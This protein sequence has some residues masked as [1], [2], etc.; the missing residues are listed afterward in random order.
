M[1][2]RVKD[3]GVDD[4]A[5]VPVETVA[6]DDALYNDGTG[7]TR[8]ADEGLMRPA[9]MS[10]VQLYIPVE[11]A[12]VTVGELGELGVCQFRDVFTRP[13]DGM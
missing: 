3:I 8:A 10:L 5:G 4:G 6:L 2:D 12:Q 11:L 13:S 1:A 9:Q 7:H